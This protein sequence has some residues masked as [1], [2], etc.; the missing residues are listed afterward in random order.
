[1]GKSVD[2]LL[3]SALRREIQALGGLA[4]PPLKAL[5]NPRLAF[6]RDHLPHGVFPLGAVHEFRCAQPES[7]AA[8]AAFVLS[9]IQVCFQPP[10]RLVWIAHE[11]PVYPPAWSSFGIEAPQ[12]LVIHPSHTTEARWCLLESLRAS[13]VQAVIANWNQL[14]MTT[15]RQF[16]LAVE[17]SG[18][19]AFLLNNHKRPVQQNACFSRWVVQSA[20]SVLPDDLPGV[21]YPTWHIALQKMRHGLPGEWTMV[22]TPD[23]FQSV[24]SLRQQRYV[25]PLTTPL[26]KIG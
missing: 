13:G 26:R 16:Q 11:Q 21:G 4:T 10:L 12:V 14:D 15:S 22:W 23:G 19:T 2:P 17:S 1:M 5:P 6:L 8:S 3:L 20:P 25:T 9:L 18:V 24:S 7:W